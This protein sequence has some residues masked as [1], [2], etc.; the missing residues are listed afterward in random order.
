MAPFYRSYDPDFKIHVD[1]IAGIQ[2]LYGPPDADE[3]FTPSNIVELNPISD[4]IHYKRFCSE[5]RFDAIT[6][7][8]F[9]SQLYTFAFFQ[10]LYVRLDENGIVDNYPKLITEGWPGLKKNLDAAFYQPAIYTYKL[11]SDLKMKRAQIS[12]PI[13]YFFKG[14]KFWKNENGKFLDGYPRE[15]VRE[16]EGL[17]NDIDAAFTWS[18]NGKIYI[19]KGQKI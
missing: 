6:E 9:N 5:A 1:D 4:L 8:M 3:T 14:S 13:T 16:W 11:A 18:M 7:V 10:D 2:A 15:I 17:P 19:I 12:P